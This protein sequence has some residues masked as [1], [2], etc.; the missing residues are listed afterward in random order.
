MTSNAARTTE[1]YLDQCRRDGGLRD[2]ASSLPLPDPLR[3]SLV[4]RVFGRP[5]FVDEDEVRRFADDVGTVFDLIVSLPERLFGGDMIEFCEALRLPPALVPACLRGYGR[6]RPPRYGRADMY[7]DGVGF[8]LL[9][10]NID[11]EIG[12]V[13]KA[14]ELPRLFADSPAFRRFAS[15][16][17]LR[18]SQPAERFAAALRAAAEPLCGARDPVVV[19][20]QFSTPGRDDDGTQASR[21]SLAAVMRRLG[22]DFRVDAVGEIVEKDGRLHH[23]GVPVDVVVRG[24]SAYDVV[25]RPDGRRS[26]EPLFR[27]A[28]QSGVVLWTELSSQL[29]AN[30]A[31]FAMLSDPRHCT[32]FSADE[33][34]AIDRVVPWTRALDPGFDLADAPWL[35]DRDDLVLKPSYFYGGIGVVAGWE[36]DERTWLAALR[37]AATRGAVVQRRVVP[38]AE[39]VVAPGGGLADWH[40]AWG[41]FLAPDG[42]SGLYARLLPANVSAVI[43][44]HADR[45][46][47]VAGVFTV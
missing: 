46:T 4:D 13:D 19:L 17:D 37:S 31:C 6:G 38:R 2:A 39:P 29:F 42:C 3:D 22:M 10:F 8:R 35:L 7:H 5:L 34:A 28:E 32:N 20:A 47:Q 27:V 40:A 24:F 1:E 33:L 45:R 21:R 36:H 11:S 44:V 41:L 18:F 26:T 12:G 9:E 23:Q 14:G 25:S 15:G 30:K 43:G 16:R